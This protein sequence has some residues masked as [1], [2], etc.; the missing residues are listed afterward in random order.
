MNKIATNRITISIVGLGILLAAVTY[1]VA[2][3]Y[4]GGSAAVGAIIAVAN[5]YLFGWIADQ[6]V[7]G[8]V[9]KRTGLMF[10][11][12]VKM[13]ALMALIYF[14]ISRHW[15]EPIGFMVGISALVIGVIVG[16]IHYLY[17]GDNSAGSES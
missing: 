4:S 13:G 14:L 12:V 7:K 17:R 6:V 15:I 2:G 16:S 9:R 10:L 3:I 8:S 5:F 1:G 11:L